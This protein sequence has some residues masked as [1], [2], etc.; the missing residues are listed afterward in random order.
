MT[1]CLP[2]LAVAAALA[3]S[4]V[5]LTGA[6]ATADPR[7]T[8][9][10][11]SGVA[12]SGPTTLRVTGSGFQSVKGGFGGIYVFFGWVD[13]PD[14]GS[15]R[16]SRGGVTGADYR[17]VPDSEDRE[18]QG[19]QRF[20][21]FPGSDTEYAANG[22]TIGADGR[23]SLSLVVPGAT[24]SALDRDGATTQVDCREVTCGVITVGAHGVKNARNESFTPVSFAAGESGAVAAA[25]SA[26]ATA[27]PGQAAA[28]VT[29]AKP[30]LA[31][32][33]ATAVEGRVLTFTGRGFRAGEQVVATLD[34][35]IASV[36]PLTA[37]QSGEV[38]GVLQMPATTLAG[39]HLLRLTAPASGAS[40]VLAFDVAAAPVAA[41]TD[42]NAEAAATPA[43]TVRAR[44]FLALSVLVLLITTA[45][46]L[47]RLSRRRRIARVEARRAG[48]AA[49]PPPLPVQ[50]P[51]ATQTLTTLVPVPSRGE[52]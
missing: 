3:T 34:D 40:P 13:D 38:A 37:G 32:D 21:A 42:D 8:V 27:A 45:V 22:G 17:Y 24:F 49:A 51:P 5:A 41:T 14:G 6:P 7:V 4:T 9:S 36:G 26:A 31:I 16:P 47:W 2:A 43:G 35:G 46:S 52:Q 10:P 20:V 15:W 1:R 44:W 39:S 19:Y 48:R 18:N 33:Q 23:L 11:A 12:S 29:A 50:R 25:P 28:A 30:T